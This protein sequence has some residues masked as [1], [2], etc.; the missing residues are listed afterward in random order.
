[1]RIGRGR[2]SS[3]VEDRRGMRLGGGRSI[4]IGTVILALVAMY[5]GIDP[6]VVLQGGSPTGY[7]EQQEK[8]P[9]PPE[10]DEAARF[11]SQVLADTEDTWRDLFQRNGMQYRDPKLVLFSGATSTAGTPSI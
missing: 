1:M 9:A 5:F 4:G 10:N 7:V 3:N 11:V 2:E 8:A 6:S